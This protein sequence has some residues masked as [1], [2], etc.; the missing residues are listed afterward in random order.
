MQEKLSW[1]DIGLRMQRPTPACSRR[2]HM[3][4]ERRGM[5]RQGMHNDSCSLIELLTHTGAWTPEETTQLRNI[6]R[7]LDERGIK[8]HTTPKFWKMV[9]EWMGNL[10][11]PDQCWSK[12]CVFTFS[13]YTTFSDPWLGPLL[14]RQ[15]HSQ[16]LGLNGDP[17]TQEYSYRGKLMSKSYCQVLITTSGLRGST[18]TRRMK[19]SG[20]TSLTR[21]G[22]C[23]ARANLGRDGPLS[24]RRTM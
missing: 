24:R 14:Y 22:T 20:G 9:S 1:V 17:L 11:S 5:R 6:M 18:L 2:Y 16:L 4:L 23:G 10:Q 3:H 15:R 7:E 8:L 19:L 12:W 21:A 13:T